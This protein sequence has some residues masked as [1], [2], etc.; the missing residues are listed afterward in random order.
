MKS[1]ALI[2]YSGRKNK[3]D[4]KFESL[5]DPYGGVFMAGCCKIDYFLGLTDRTGKEALNEK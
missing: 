3:N 2:A 5:C 1:L 4:D